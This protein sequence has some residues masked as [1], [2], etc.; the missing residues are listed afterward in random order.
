MNHPYC[1]IVFALSLLVTMALQSNAQENVRRPIYNHFKISVAVVGDSI[2]LRCMEGCAW[3]E[4]S[5][6]K[7]FDLSG[8]SINQFGMTKVGHLN[9]LRQDNKLADFMITVKRTG[10]QLIVKGNSGVHWQNLI[11]PCSKGCEEFISER[12]AR[13]KRVLEE[14]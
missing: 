11:L 1:K 14:F 5:F 8:Q 3:R 6:V 10:D 7:P 4:L 2:K 12:G 9:H 13:T